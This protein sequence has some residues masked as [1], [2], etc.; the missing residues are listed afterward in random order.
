MENKE[1]KVTIICMV[2]ILSL[3]IVMLRKINIVKEL[4]IDKIEL[5]E[6]Q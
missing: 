3:Q 2:I 6:K 5:Q 1:F 4:L